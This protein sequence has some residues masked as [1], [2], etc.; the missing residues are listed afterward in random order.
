MGSRDAD[1]GPPSAMDLLPRSERRAANDGSADPTAERELRA[2]EARYRA[3]V[4]DMPGMV[5]RFLADGTL[6]FVNTAYCDYSAAAR[7]H[8]G[9]F[10][11]IRWYRV[12][13]GVR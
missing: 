5:C 4:E 13:L 10:R 2:S 7:R 9:R 6:T 8:K 11:E 12:R 1:T 3:V